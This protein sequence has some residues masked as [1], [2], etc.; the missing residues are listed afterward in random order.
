MCCDTVFSLECLYATIVGSLAKVLLY[1]LPYR[2][3]TKFYVLTAML[4]HKY[5]FYSDVSIRKN[6]L[7][8]HNT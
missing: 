8:V 5:F 3:S 7:Y 1:K 4:N 2:R 6:R